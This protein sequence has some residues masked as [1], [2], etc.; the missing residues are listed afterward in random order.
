MH[1][2][3]QEA[4]AGAAQPGGRGGLRCKGYRTGISFLPSGKVEGGALLARWEGA[5]GL[6][7]RSMP[8][9]WLGRCTAFPVEHAARDDV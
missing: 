6:D 2:A 9:Y 7:Q 8:H 4:G 3:A 1:A 5:A